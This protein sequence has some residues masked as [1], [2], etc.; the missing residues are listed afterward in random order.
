MTFQMTIAIITAA[1]ISG[2][3][4]GTHEI[5]RPAL[6]SRPRG[7]FSCNSPIF[8]WVWGGGFLGDAGVLDLAG[9]TVVHINSGIAAL[10]AAIVLGKRVGYGRENLAPHT[11][12]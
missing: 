8:Y 6:V 5:F 12:S 3:N 4:R 9:G 10:V 11:S 2:A 7:P 1:L